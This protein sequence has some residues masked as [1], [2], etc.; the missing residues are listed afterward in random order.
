LNSETCT[1][2]RTPLRTQACIQARRSVSL[3]MKLDDGEV[4]AY[5]TSDSWEE[6]L[7]AQ[8][9]W[10]AEEQK[11]AESAKG[12]Q[13]GEHVD[14]S[15]HVGLGDGDSSQEDEDGFGAYNAA[16]F[17]ELEHARAAKL[18]RVVEAHQ[19]ER[20][21]D[22]AFE[23]SAAPSASTSDGADAAALKRLTVSFEAVI[24]SLT[25]IESKVEEMSAK[26]QKLESALLSKG[27]ITGEDAEQWDGV[28]DESAYF[29]D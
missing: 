12:G 28:V 16:A 22:A 11:K 7:A 29:D 21:S 27:V 23:P 9:A 24:S 10:L 3:Q 13:E 17:R 25:R 5:D 14:E 1:H 2:C 6:Q 4:D 26:I 15:V 19:A 18:L 20:A 8:R